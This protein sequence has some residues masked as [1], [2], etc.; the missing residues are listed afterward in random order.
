MLGLLGDELNE[1]FSRFHPIATKGL[2]GSEALCQEIIKM[3]DQNARR[4]QDRVKEIA[5][6]V[7]GVTIP[8]RFG[9]CRIADIVATA[10]KALVLRSKEKE[11]SLHTEGLED[12]PIVEADEGRLFNAFYNL[13][14]NAI[15]EVTSGG[16]ITVRGGLEDQGQTIVS[17]CR[18][19]M[20]EE[21]LPR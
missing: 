20:E 13:I 18:R 2:E 8:P 21:C 5:D 1:H 4:I 11:I 12:L 10:S 3:I 15:P 19:I 9:P 6:A 16:T 17:I 7:K 14:K